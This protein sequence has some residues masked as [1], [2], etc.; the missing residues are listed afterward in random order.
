M[1]RRHLIWL[2]LLLPAL[3]GAALAG[4]ALFLPD[5]SRWWGTGRP[6][7]G[8][9]YPFEVVWSFEPPRRGAIVSS[10]LPA[11]DRVFV[12]VIQDGA[13]T[14]GRA[15]CLDRDTGR[16]RWAFDDAGRMQHLFSSPCLAAGRL[17]VG[18]GMH[19]NFSSKLYCLDAETGK[20]LWHFETAGH[21]ESSPCV[22]GGWVYFGAGDDG[23]YGLDAATGKVAWHFSGPFHI[24]TSPA[25]AGGRLYAGSGQSLSYRQT[26]AFC[27]DAGTG[28]VVW[29]VATD[30]PV[31]GSPAV[32]GGEV[33]FGLG[34]GRFLEPPP[35]PEQ[36]AGAVL[37]LDAGTGRTLWRWDGD[38]VFC[39]PV[40]DARH[41]VFG[42]RDG[43][44]FCLDRRS[45]TVCWK[46]DLGSP[47]VARP[48]VLGPHVWAVGSAGRLCRLDA[49]SGRVQAAFD[50]AARTRTRPQ[51][52]S[53]PA[54]V[55]EPG[56]PGRCRLYLGSEL[57]N[58]A[59]SAAV[60]YCLRDGEGP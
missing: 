51:V 16:V 58:A 20:K 38:A 6:A 50:L 56:A 41:V 28:A 11:G 13:F 21:V 48:A 59:S 34:N 36:A 10:P 60:L 2:G 24:D 47:V 23:L 22:A 55:P 31:W 9:A 33:F 8:P 1:N 32:D 37:C 12:G 26:E 15:Y 42:S 35:A 44:C 43:S 5:S 18:E 25:V 53:S 7:R 40:V 30:L 14:S 45:G 4:G 49:E 29:R 52:F 19:Q 17:Y 46:A 57:A 3:L 54:A 39:R 27:L